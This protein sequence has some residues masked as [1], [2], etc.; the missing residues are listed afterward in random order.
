MLFFGQ[1]H[2]ITGTIISQNGIALESATIIVKGTN[3]GT[4]SDAFGQFKLTV[5]TKTPTL[6]VSLVGYKTKTI[7][8][9]NNSIEIQLAVQNTTLDEVILV[10]SRNPKRSKLETSVPVDVINLATI[11]NVTA[12]TSINDILTYL[13]PSFN[14]NRQSA[15]DGTEH[16][17]PAS[18]R[19]L[20]P[21]QVLVLV[22]GKRR[23]TTSLVNYQNTVGNGSVGT[24]LSS[25]PASAIKRIEVLRDGAAAQYGSDAIAGVIN[26]VLKDNTGLEINTTYGQTSRNDGET[27]NLNLNY[28]HKIGDD[29]G[30][31]NI[32]F[33][34]NNREKTSRSQ[35]HNLVIFDQSAYG[36]FFA[37]DFS[38][39]N[40]S[41]IDDDLIAAAGLTRNDF[42]FQVGDAKI[43]N[44][45][46]FLNTVIPL[47]KDAEFYLSGGFNQKNG[48][49]FGFRRLPSETYN[50]VSS[51][52]PYGFQ[53]EL[54]SDISDVSVIS[55][56]RFKFS[57]WKLDVSNT[58]GQNVFKYDVSNTNNASLGA[59]S[60][61]SFDAG[62]HSF[63]QNTLNADIT[64]SFK[65]IYNGLDLAFGAE[66][67]VER[68]NIKAGNIGSYVN[69]GA[70]SFP[71]FSPLNEVNKNRNSV[72][73][74]T[75]VEVDFTDKFLVGIAGR[76]EDYSDFGNTTNGKITSRYKATDNFFIRASVSTG[77]RAPSLQQQ[78]FNNI[79][80]DV[81]DGKILNSGI[82]R[83]DS[84]IAKQ[85]GIPKLK[86]E[87][88][89]DYSIGIVYSPSKQFHITV[90]AYQVKIDN[91][92]ILTGNLGNDPYGDAVP[93][94]QSLFAT[95]GAQTGRFFTNA[96]NTTTNGIDLVV[97]YNLT[98]GKGTLNASFLYN[99]NKNKVDTKLN[100][101]PTAFIGQEDVYFGPQE[102][103]LIETNTPKHKGTLA[104]NYA[105]NKFNFLLRNT[106]FG[107]VTRDGFP[108]GIA[109]KHNGKVVTDLTV[110]YKITPKIQFIAGANNLLDVFPD[111]QAYE[112]SYFG[113]FKYAPVQMGTTGAYYFGRLNFSL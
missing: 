15:S 56:L 98:L 59:N 94:L 40:A 2:E 44:V 37:Y 14:S 67:R 72:A 58:V 45:Q 1:N 7:D 47:N 95:Y 42:N 13:I 30:F 18:L 57:D 21:D 27:T 46:G 50:V 101:I 51:L 103:S 31:I 71:G 75:D 3:N 76:Y 64:R 43:K 87:T 20:G 22:N 38:N 60:P 39:P 4:I 61:T 78:Y 74:Y 26:L 79:A 83:T 109:Q 93:E 65:T 29:G 25:I 24:D 34:Y 28:G 5:E 66:Y 97:D 111:E 48:T 77:F 92:I 104:L 16:I 19:G 100:H 8:V 12:Q 70:Q 85:L 69:G 55:G 54:K 102:R 36:N 81:V 53:P 9:K 112:N 73:V 108:F 107:E 86:Q 11:K 17:D 63:L 105:L 49:G 96:I 35:N 82:F 10:G 62:S 52:F 99:Y 106:Y 88:S 68:Y 91:R 113:V 89:N 41:Q 32:T 84:D 6:I 33:E 80:T 23:H 110:S 90:D